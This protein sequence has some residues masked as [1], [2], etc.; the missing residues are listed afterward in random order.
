MSREPSGAV[1]KALLIRVLR[2]WS[3]VQMRSPSPDGP[4]SHIPAA[5][6]LQHLC[7]AQGACTALALTLLQDCPGFL[8]EELSLHF[9]SRQL[10]GR[11]NC[12]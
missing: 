1:C 3:S 5:L 12:T 6:S 7:T 11:I 9:Q 10:L 8:R 2:L 4:N